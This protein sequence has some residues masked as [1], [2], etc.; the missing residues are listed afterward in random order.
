MRGS[1]GYHLKKLFFVVLL[2]S[3]ISACDDKNSTGDAFIKD[4]KLSENEQKLL[5]LS[6]KDFQ[7][8]D[9][10]LKNDS[11]RKVIVTIDYYE[12]GKFISQISQ[13]T[14]LISKEQPQDHLRALILR[15]TANNSEEKWFTNLTVDSSS[16]LS[17]SSFQNIEHIVEGEYGSSQSNVRTGPIKMGE[18]KIIST[19]LYSNDDEFAYLREIETEE[20]FMKIPNNDLVYLFSIELQ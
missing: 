14:H 7:I 9:I 15:Q 6:N 10:E 17:T 16:E 18:K 20:D 19:L 5:S 12:N 8:F 3:F 13:L 2:L 4:V 1:R 11:I